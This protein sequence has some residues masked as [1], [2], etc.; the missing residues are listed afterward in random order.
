MYLQLGKIF[1]L[2]LKSLSDHI[3]TLNALN[4]IPYDPEEV[5]IQLNPKK[6][7]KR[8]KIAVMESSWVIAL[9]PS[10]HWNWN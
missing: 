3:L 1:L 6:S 9:K 2:S 4:R 5:Y 10:L 7:P 8:F